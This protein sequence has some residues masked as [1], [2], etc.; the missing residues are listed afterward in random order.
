MFRHG[1]SLMAHKFLQKTGLR[2]GGAE[3]VKFCRNGAW[4]QDFMEETYN[5]NP[6]Q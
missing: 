6:L 1:C 3:S 4:D 2:A 5:D